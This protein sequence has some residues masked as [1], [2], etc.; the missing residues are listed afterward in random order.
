[1]SEERQPN[2]NCDHFCAG[3]RMRREIQED[4]DLTAAG[5]ADER[6]RMLEDDEED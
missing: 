6:R 1:M 5:A 4:V 3:I 2:V